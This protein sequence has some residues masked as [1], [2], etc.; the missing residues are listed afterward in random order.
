MIARPSE[1]NFAYREYC[2]A[3]A[4]IGEE[5]FDFATWFAIEKGEQSPVSEWSGSPD[6]IDPDNYWIDDETGERI[7]VS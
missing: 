5:P 3:R 1:V 2:E 4:D 6:P 7:R